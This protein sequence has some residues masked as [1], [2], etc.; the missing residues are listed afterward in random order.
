MASSDTYHPRSVAVI[1]NNL[2]ALNAALLLGQLTAEVKLITDLPVFLS[3][4]LQPDMQRLYWSTVLQAMKNPQI[5]FYFNTVSVSTEK[6][7]GTF[8]LKTVQKPQYINSE[9]CTGCKQCE[10]SCSTL[11]KFTVDGAQLSR[12]AV[13]KPAPGSKA[14]PSAMEIEKNAMPPC[15]AACPLGINV[16]GFVALLANGK[17]KEAY[18]LI[19]KTAP[20]GGILGRLCKHPCED[21]CTRSKIDS[22]LSI[23][24][25]H[26]FAYDNVNGVEKF[27][28]TSGIKG[29]VA[30]I[31]SGPA[32]L[33]AAWELKRRGYEPTVFE[34]HST[35]GGLLA[36]GIPR[37]R[38]SKEIREREIRRLIDA[39]IKV[40]TGITVG[41]D[42]DFAYLRE[43][44][45]RAFFLAI[46]ALHNNRLNI[47]G[48]ELEGVIDCMSFLIS[49]NQMN[50]I[51]V[52]SNIVIIGDG[53]TAVDSARVAIRANKGSVKII[54]WTVPEEVTANS[55]ELQEA[56]EEGVTV[57]YSAAPVEILG[58]GTRVNGIRFQRTRLTEEIMRNGRHRP[59]PIPGTDFVVEADHVIIAIGQS[60]DASQLNLEGLATDK[61]SG[62]ILVNPVTL[63]TSIKGV[64][65]GGDCRRGPDN[66]VD[67]MADGR[68][69]AE[70]I[71]RFLTG[72]DMAWD[73][74]VSTPLIA[75]VDLEL[76][77]VSPV[78]RA[79]MPY[80]DMASR[81]SSYE[82]TTMGLSAEQVLQEAGR[83]LNC[84][85]CSECM[86]CVKVCEANAINHQAAVN[87][88]Y[89]D[90]N[91]I[92]KFPTSSLS[93]S[94]DDSCTAESGY[95]SGIY[96]YSEHRKDELN[97]I[98]SIIR[99]AMD[100]LLADKAATIEIN[101]S[102]D[103]PCNTLLPD[104]CLE[105]PMIAPRRGVFLCRCNGNNS[106]NIDFDYLKNALIKSEHVQYV[107][108]ID[109]A[110]I[111]AGSQA[112]KEAVKLQE[113]NR[114][115]IA[116]CRCCNY[117]QVCYSCNDRRI[118]CQKYL[119]TA[120]NDYDDCQ[121]D[122]V[123]IRE[124][125]AWA[126]HNDRASATSNA[127]KMIDAIIS[128]NVLIR[129]QYS[130]SY[131]IRP[132]V[133]FLNS[134]KSTKVAS[135]ILSKLGFSINM[136]EV[137]GGAIEVNGLPGDYEVK[138]D[139]SD[140]FRAGAIVLDISDRREIAESLSSTYTGRL[141][142][143]IALS[144]DSE[145]K[146]GNSRGK[147]LNAMARD[148]LFIYDNSVDGV[149]GGLTLASR[150][151]A[152]LLSKRVSV[153]PDRAYIDSQLCRGCGKCAEICLLIEM[154]LDDGIQLNSYIEQQLCTGC[155]ACAAIC[156]TGAISLSRAGIRAAGALLKAV[157]CS[158]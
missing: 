153:P 138:S 43:R 72:R 129:P 71:D 14:V 19:N 147:Y 56:L 116:A 60:A 38:L 81:K 94:V 157:L 107:G 45:Y 103:E 49:L 110:C 95:V 128:R 7:N 86:E 44:G 113:L 67:A 123:N 6:R 65:A 70:S 154:R 98:S 119:E 16:Q 130:Q 151:L 125:S 4:G 23:R 68:R 24:A 63:E 76:V 112:V 54:S 124:L 118:L 3:R 34:S 106:E 132:S 51:F 108:E 22:P 127:Q 109:Q 26:R 15:R 64:F 144:S 28:E 39:G 31:G 74:D 1:G 99:D 96:D 32:G 13:H 33:M 146:Q 21:S 48:E 142:T 158:Y 46:G 92:W 97:D 66:V 152:Y 111:E 9:L 85:L 59:V 12:H 100:Y 50:E 148:G 84:A 131:P 114:I 87:V 83:C 57:E 27:A 18:E 140:I 41:R 62:T 149:D 78:K 145:G 37:F 122:Y 137:S 150:L 52:G 69:A 126:H 47:P 75:D 135:D 58:D 40:R 105:T 25:L 134:S 80:L 77:T 35:Y 120:L 42:I 8:H 139:T 156:P 79:E 82:E 117:Q 115:I 5:K 17:V 143:R 20:L 93:Y 2:D 89:F 11:L 73:R 133:L 155:G 101:R 36:T 141:F 90:V 104:K 88:E 136:V 102:I 53:N 55:D 91:A 121:I 29:K 10:N 30:I 61:N